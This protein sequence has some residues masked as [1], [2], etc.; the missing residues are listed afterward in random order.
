MYYYCRK[1]TTINIP[2]EMPDLTNM[3][4]AFY[5]CWEANKEEG[6][7]VPI[8]S[9]NLNASYAYASDNNNTTKSV[10]I[11]EFINDYTGYTINA[12]S[13]FLYS[14]ILGKCYPI[15]PSS[16]YSSSTNSL[17]MLNCNY[18]QR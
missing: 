10:I 5:D 14:K 11:K 4:Y 9:N 8:T 15:L 1:L 12:K 13:M 16:L 2:E 7:I 6:L 18:I 3:S 17:Y